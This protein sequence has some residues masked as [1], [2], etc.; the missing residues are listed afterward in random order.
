MTRIVLPVEIPFIM[1]ECELGVDFDHQPYEPTIIH[2]ADNSYE[3]CAESVSI[4]RVDIYIPSRESTDGA[5]MEIQ[6]TM[7]KE[8]RALL[9]EIILDNK[10]NWS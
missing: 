1:R 7:T 4:N 9:E 8:D 5:L 2:P 3:G 10:E 6:N